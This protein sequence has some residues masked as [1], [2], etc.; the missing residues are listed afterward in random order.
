MPTINFDRKKLEALRQAHAEA[1]K[2]GRK[3]FVFEGNDLYTPYA[4]YL[5][6]Y[7]DSRIPK[8]SP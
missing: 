6:E 5:I 4:G 3:E 8:E 2:E 7:L 1:L